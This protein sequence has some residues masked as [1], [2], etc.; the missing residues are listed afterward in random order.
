[1][2]EYCGPYLVTLMAIDDDEHDWASAP[3]TSP[4]PP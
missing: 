4:Y 2:K 1:M 3:V